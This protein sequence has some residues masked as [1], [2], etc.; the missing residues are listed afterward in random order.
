[1]ITRVY[2]ICL[3]VDELTKSREFYEAKLGFTVNSEDTGFVDYRLGETPLALFQ[4]SDATAMFP[5]KYMQRGSS[6]VIALAVDNVQ[7]ECDH[8]VQL[9]VDIFEQPKMTPWGQT[10]AYLHDPDGYI[11]ELTN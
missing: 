5:E 11:I 2:A 6:A 9:G 8:L 1:M 7:K 10:V 4:K 3:I